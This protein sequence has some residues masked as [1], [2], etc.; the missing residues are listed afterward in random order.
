MYAAHATFAR[1]QECLLIEWR[2]PANVFI[3]LREY[4]PFLL[5]WFWPWSDDLDIRTWPRFEFLGQRFQTL[6]HEQD[7]HVHT[8]IQTDATERITAVAFA[9]MKSY[10][11]FAS[12][13]HS[14]L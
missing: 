11:S 4:I 1:Q 14:A 13:G 8:E 7:R 6:E 9:V 5:Q 12:N 10:T 3:Q 2:P